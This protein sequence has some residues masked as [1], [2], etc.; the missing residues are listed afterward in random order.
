M[1]QKLGLEIQNLTSLQ[2]A[3]YDYEKIYV[4]CLFSQIFIMVLDS[5]KFSTI[6]FFFQT[7]MEKF[8]LMEPLNMIVVWTYI[9]IKMVD[10]A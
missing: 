1:G 9:L 8:W 10:W 4:F 2:C 7:K 5:F 3:V 6:H